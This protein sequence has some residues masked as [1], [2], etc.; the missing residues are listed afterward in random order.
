MNAYAD[1]IRARAEMQIDAALEQ[2]EHEEELK[3]PPLKSFRLLDVAALRALPPMRW[4]IHHV[5][6]TE[7]FGAIYGPSGSGKSFL[8]I[9][10]A[11]AVAGASE[12]FGHKVKR[13]SVLYVAL[14]GGAGISKRI[15]AWEMANEQ[16]YP[17][18]VRFLIESFKLLDQDDVLALA[19]AIDAAGGADVIL[20]D[21][22]NRAAPGADE[23]GPED[24][25][26]ILEAVK[27]L[28]QMTGG[29]V[30]LVHHSGKDTTK[31]M[32]GHSSLFAGMDA[33]IAT[34][35]SA[36]ARSWCVEKCK[37]GPEG[38]AKQ[39][40]LSVLDVDEDEDGDPITS[41]AVAQPE[42]GTGDFQATGPRPPKGG[43]QRI[44]Y[45]ALL[46]LFRESRAFG[47]A[48][49]PAVRPCLELEAVVPLIRERLTVEPKRRTERA[50][51]AITGLVASGV[52]GSNEGWI[53]LI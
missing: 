5:L 6:P 14:E 9:D 23:N 31:G 46:P 1:S 41:C 26:R 30:L 45:D 47:K 19:A 21:T 13:G 17:D 18:G 29:L 51:Q 11:A 43:N 2:F 16:A 4:R 36:G 52:I 10:M 28:Q 49:A 24:A 22:L 48:G 7:G 44:V 39:F 42:D 50:R 53:W 38:D 8:V 37:D 25:G 35:R 3:G 27:S 33:V 20:I 12:W 32:R 40:S 34:S 15:K